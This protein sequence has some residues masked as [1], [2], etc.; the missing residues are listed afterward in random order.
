MT[1]QMTYHL[2]GI[3]RYLGKINMQIFSAE[4]KLGLSFLDGLRL[5]MFQA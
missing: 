2:Q 1:L 4:S 3:I 5:V